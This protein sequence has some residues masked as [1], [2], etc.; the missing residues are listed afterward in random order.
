MGTFRVPQP[1]RSAL[2][3]L[4]LSDLAADWSLGSPAPDWSQSDR[5]DSSC[6]RATLA[7]DNRNAEPARMNRR[8]PVLS[9]V[10][11]TS[12]FFKVESNRIREQSRYQKPSQGVNSR[13]LANRNRIGVDQ[14]IAECQLLVWVQSWQILHQTS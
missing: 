14:M 13:L 4:S 12:G 1:C 8:R 5:S 10:T 2:A 9:A 6:A 11:T 3:P 7:P